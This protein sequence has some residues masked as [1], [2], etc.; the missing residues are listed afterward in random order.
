[1]GVSFRGTIITCEKMAD[2]S[3]PTNSRTTRNGIPQPLLKRLVFPPGTDQFF[4]H[5]LPP[6]L[7][8]FLQIAPFA[9][10]IIN[11]I[12]WAPS[13]PRLITIP[14]AKTLL[15]PAAQP[16]LPTSLGCPQLPHR[17]LA[18]C[19]IS[20]D[21]GGSIEFMSECT[22]IDKPFCLYDANQH[23]NTER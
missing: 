10:C 12:Y 23:T 4:R 11:G 19:D 5:K 20:A 14:D 18:I 9:S 8:I 7:M 15:Q 22:T 17:L 2:R 13:A 3:M 1:M 21:P 6:C 16:W